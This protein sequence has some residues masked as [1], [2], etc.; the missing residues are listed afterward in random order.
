MG[1]QQRTLG[2]KTD[3][4][5]HQHRADGI[6]VWIEGNIGASIIG[7]ILFFVFFGGGGGGVR[8]GSMVYVYRGHKGILLVI[9]PAAIVA[10]RCGVA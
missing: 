7:T 5:H 6:P 4:A 3:D 2:L 1:R 9:I 10:S 8:G